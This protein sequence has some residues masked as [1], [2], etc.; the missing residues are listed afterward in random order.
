MLAPAR[1]WALR[2]LKAH[3]GQAVLAGGCPAPWTLRVL[4]DLVG[5][6]GS[7]L[8]VEGNP[9]RARHAKAL[10][11]SEGWSNLR[12][13]ADLASEIDRP[14]H[15][16]RVLLDDGTCLIDR[17]ALASIL[18]TLR[19]AA[20]VV[21]VCRRGDKRRRDLEQQLS[22]PGFTETC[23]LGFLSRQWE[24]GEPDRIA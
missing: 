6:S 3:P 24:R 7:V 15:V 23:C 16:D 9:T 19:P 18:A 17:E 20:R 8:T 2:E 5:D 11:A 13:V 12:V 21:A 22:R 4:R 14:I 10:I 1:R